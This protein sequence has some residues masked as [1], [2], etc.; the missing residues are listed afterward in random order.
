MHALSTIAEQINLTNECPIKDQVPL[1]R[2]LITTMVTLN[3]RQA[4]V[5]MYH[6]KQIKPN[7]FVIVNMAMLFVELFKRPLVR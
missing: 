4:L 5:C 7:W 3:R 1:K 6:I 2:T